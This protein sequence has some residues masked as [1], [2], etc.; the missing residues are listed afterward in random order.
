MRICLAILGAVIAV[1]AAA[2]ASIPVRAHAQASPS[3]SGGDTMIIGGKRA[4]GSC[5]SFPIEYKD[6]PMIPAIGVHTNAAGVQFGELVTA[7]D[8]SGTFLFTLNYTDSAPQTFTVEVTAHGGTGGTNSGMK[9]KV[10]EVRR[11]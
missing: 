7:G 1:S 9:R 11:L 6:F 10:I 5:R 4:A 2:A 3:L 8:G